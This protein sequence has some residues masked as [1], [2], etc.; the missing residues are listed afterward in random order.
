MTTEETPLAPAL[1]RTDRSLPIALLRARE[2]LMIPVRE[3]LLQSRITEQK[4]RVLRVV[5]ESGPIEQTRIA[6]KAC[7][8]QPSLTRIMHALDRDGFLVRTTNEHDKRQTIAV[9]TDAGRQLI[10]E[11]TALS[12][13]LF[14]RLENQFGTEKMDTLLDLLDELQQVQ[15]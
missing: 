11:H 10:L 3:M 7:L 15:L 5:E 6:Q 12:E 1:K 2:T 4:Y 14:L 9:I 13:D 8:H